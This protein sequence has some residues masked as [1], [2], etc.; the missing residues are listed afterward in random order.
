MFSESHNKADLEQMAGRVRGNPNTGTGIHALMVVY[1]ADDH[2]SDW[3]FLECELD[4]R[5]AGQVSEVMELHKAA[6]EQDGQEYVL[7]KDIQAIQSRHRY[8]RYDYIK[9]EF[10][11][12]TG[13]EKCEKQTQADRQELNAYMEV[14]DEVLYYYSDQSGLTYAATGRS[15]LRDNWFQYSKV[16]HAPDRL[17]GPKE[18]ATTDLLNYLQRNK[19]LDVEITP[20]QVSAVMQEVYRFIDI[21]GSSALG[22]ATFTV[23]SL[24]Q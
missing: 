1:D 11:H 2:W 14:F 22:F 18:T 8:L 23:S 17:A 15:E 19:L 10:F 7:K 16:Y 24:R 20:E 5:L 4:R 3:S 6:Y 9:K 13:R 21:Y 12:F